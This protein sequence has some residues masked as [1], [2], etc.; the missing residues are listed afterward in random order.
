MRKYGIAALL[1][2]FFLIPASGAMAQTNIASASDPPADY[3][4]Y[5][6]FLDKGKQP[7]FLNGCRYRSKRCGCDKVG[8]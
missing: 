3:V 2:S 4:G 1:G 6:V 8:P 7:T 5:V